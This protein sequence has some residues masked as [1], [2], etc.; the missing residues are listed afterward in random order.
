MLTS[1]ELTNN[2]ALTIRLRNLDDMPCNSYKVSYSI[3]GGTWVAQAF[4]DP[5]P[6]NAAK[7]ITILGLNLSAPGDYHLRISVENITMADP[8]AINDSANY[9]VSQLA[10]PPVALDFTEDFETLPAFSKIRDTAG[11]GDSRRWDYQ[12]T[13]DT[14]RLRSFVLNSVTIKGQRSLSLD[15]YKSCPGNFNA[16]TGTFNMAGYNA[17]TDEVR[18]EFDYII[19]GVPKS[20]PGNEMLARGIDTKPFQIVHKYNLKSENKG[21]VTNSGSISLSDVMLNTGD[22]FSSST[23]LQF[24]QNDT[25]LIAGRSIG[26]GMTIDDVRLYTVQNDVQLLSVVAPDNFSCGITGSV[27]LTIKVRNGVNQAQNNVQLNFRLDNGSVISENIISLA[28]KETIDYTFSKLLDISTPGNHILDVW[29]SAVGD[30]YTKNDSI[31]KYS[32]RNQPLINSYP[33]SENFEAGDGY[34]YADGINSSWAYGAPAK[35]KINGAASGQKAWVTNLEGNYNDD[36]R[37]YLYSPCF[38]MSAMTNPTFSCKLALDIEN[39][40]V[41]LCDAAFMDYTIDGENWERLGDYGEGTNWYTDS[42]YRIWTIEDKTAW[43][44]AQIPLPK[45]TTNIQLRIG[46]LSDPGSAKEGIGVDDIYI[47]DEKLNPAD[48]E[49]ISVSP[50]PTE[51]GVINIE[52]SAHGGTELKLVMTDV[53][54]KEVHRASALAQE[55]YNKTTLNTPLFSTGMYFMRITIGDKTHKR[56]IVFRRR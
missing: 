25:S 51:D 38:D 34:W 13:T 17:N 44:Q 27:P 14:G 39:C 23:Q 55:G 49:I 56:K 15:A 47:F 30:S 41:I 24:G 28:G 43:H 6:A 50:N 35:P 12:N 21:K 53:M 19:H 54:G 32:L 18:L 22:N 11:F 10:N 4:S 31:L 8:V 45:G 52:W 42:N 46:M 40:N 20:S 1:T 5:L 2:E 16:V 26:N 7:A 33:Y 9:Y 36:E 29:L 3:N 48:N 37:S